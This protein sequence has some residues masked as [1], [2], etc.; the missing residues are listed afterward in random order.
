[1]RIE[2]SEPTVA[3]LSGTAK[4]P[5]LSGSASIRDRRLAATLTNP[6]LDA[7][8]VVVLRMDGG[9]RPTEGRGTRVTI[10][11]KSVVALELALA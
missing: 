4:L 5:G 6:S 8:C 9:V 1:M 2:V 10:P 7:D 11:K 3:V